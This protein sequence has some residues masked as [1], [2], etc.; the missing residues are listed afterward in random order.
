M[1]CELFSLRGTIMCVF[2]V[3]LVV[4][5]VCL[6]TGAY[7]QEVSTPLGNAAVWTFGAWHIDWYA[8]AIYAGIALLLSFQWCL[9]L[10]KAESWS[11]MS[12]FL[13]VLNIFLLLFMLLCVYIAYNP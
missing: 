3:L 2:N 10:P 5:L 6:D 1:K 4:V 8:V 13:T 9:L 12:L 11:I 7:L